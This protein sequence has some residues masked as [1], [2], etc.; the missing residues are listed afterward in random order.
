MSKSQ[1]PFPKSQVSSSILHLI[2]FG[3]FTSLALSLTGGIEFIEMKE[4][5]VPEGL[6]LQG[7]ASDYSFY[8]FPCATFMPAKQKSP[9]TLLG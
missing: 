6:I 3:T 9:L 8:I 1:P 2:A 7:L 5:R 4:R